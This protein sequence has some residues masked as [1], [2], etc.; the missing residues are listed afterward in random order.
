MLINATNKTGMGVQYALTPTQDLRVGAG[1]Q[2]RS[3]DTDAI[4]GAGNGQEVTVLG[5]VMA[6][7]VGIELSG[8]NALVRI[9]ASGFI[10]STGEG[11]FLDGRNPTVVNAGTIQ[12]ANDGIRAMS[13]A[14]TGTVRITNSGAIFSEMDAVYIDTQQNTI[15]RNSGLIVST[16]GDSFDGSVR[17]DKVFNT[18]VM[19]GGIDLQTD[20]DL[21]DGRG[22]IVFGTILGGSGNDRFVLG[23]S[24][25][26]ID[27]GTDIDT[28]DFRSAGAVKVALDGSFINAGAAAKGDTYA[29]MENIFGSLTGADS[30]AGNIEAN[31]IRGFG[32]NDSLFAVDGNDTLTGGAGVDTISTG[33]GINQIR[34]NALSER[35]DVLTNFDASNDE[36]WIKASGFGGNLGAPGMLAAGRF[37]SGTDKQADDAGDRFIYNEVSDRLY[38]DRDGTGTGFA[39]V[40]LCVNDG[41]FGVMTNADIFIF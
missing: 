40:L 28:L 12:A 11:I 14:T 31:L 41:A 26:T 17:V 38:F 18:G 8:A 7:W 25:E 34:F 32:G 9:G 19:D 3:L 22:G 37:T 27:G 4:T 29:G 33:F 1:I 24:A 5:R 35:G 2:V 39:A 36:I 21:Y 6:A 15:L 23:S 10:I 20:N 30:L 16:T 13:G